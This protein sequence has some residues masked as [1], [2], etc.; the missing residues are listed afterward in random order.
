MAP[1]SLEEYKSQMQLNSNKISISKT[2]FTILFEIFKTKVLMYQNNGDKTTFS[3]SSI[4]KT[5]L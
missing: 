4:H 2:A 1:A 5:F 3:F